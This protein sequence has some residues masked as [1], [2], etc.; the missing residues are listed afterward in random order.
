MNLG[1]RPTVGGASLRVEVNVFDFE[2][3][4]YGARLRIELV[5]RLRGE[6]KFAGI[7]E[8]RAQIARDAASAREALARLSAVDGRR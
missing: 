5:G 3:D 7:E 8:L 2:G 4:L 1:I 6:Q